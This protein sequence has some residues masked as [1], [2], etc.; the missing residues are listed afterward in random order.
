MG[1]DGKACWFCEADLAVIEH[2]SDEFQ[3]HMMGKCSA[4][5]DGPA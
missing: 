2:D 4:P 3:R 1:W 5:D